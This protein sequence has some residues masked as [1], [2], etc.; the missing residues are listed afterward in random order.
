MTPY[1]VGIFLYQNMIQDHLK[2]QFPILNMK[3]ECNANA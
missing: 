1:I 3:D 2:E